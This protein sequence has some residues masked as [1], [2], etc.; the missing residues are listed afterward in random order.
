MV[1]QGIKVVIF[2]AYY[3]QIDGQIKRLNQTLKQ[4]LRHYINYTQNNWV[5]LL[6]VTQF[7]YNAILQEGINILLFKANY[8]Y[9]LKTS[10]SPQQVKKSSKTVKKRVET[11]INLYKDFQELAKIV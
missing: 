6:P 11:L 8:S 2:T 10:L 7:V 4:Y 5:L 3:P 1:E 9:K